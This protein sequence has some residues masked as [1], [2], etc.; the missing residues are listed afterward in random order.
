MWLQE[1][2]KV[3]EG[4]RRGSDSEIFDD[5]TMLALRMEEGTLS[6]GMQVASKS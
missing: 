1:F 3:K 4:D 5:A 2:L 6:Q